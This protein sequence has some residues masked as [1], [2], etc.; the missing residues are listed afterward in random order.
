MTET[1]LN[2]IYKSVGELTGAVK[3]LGEKIEANEHRNVTAIAEANKSRAEVHR[4][5][6]DLVDRTSRLEGD[7]AIMAKTVAGVQAVTDDV[8]AMRERARGAGTLGQWLIKFGGWLLGAAATVVSFYTYL[9]GRP[10]P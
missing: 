5:L 1:S 9:T 8:K 4:R 3:S 2:D 10:P 6:D 7:T